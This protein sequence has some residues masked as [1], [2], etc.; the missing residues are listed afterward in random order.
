MERS[1]IDYLEN[2]ILD[3]HEALLCSMEQERQR[4]REKQQLEIQVL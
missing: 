2:R 4:E 1:E 3:M